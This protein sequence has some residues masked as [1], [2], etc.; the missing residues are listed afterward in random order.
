MFIIF[1][2]L[3]LI[4]NRNV[5]IHSS[6]ENDR[7]FFCNHFIYLNPV[8][9]FLQMYITI[10]RKDLLLVLLHH[11]LIIFKSLLQVPVFL[12]FLCYFLNNII[13]FF[14]LFRRGKAWKVMWTLKRSDVWRLF[15]QKTAH[16]LTDFIHFRWVSAKS[17][18]ST[19][20]MGTHSTLIFL[21]ISKQFIM[22]CWCTVFTVIM[23]LPL[24]SLIYCTVHHHVLV[25]KLSWSEVEAKSVSLYLSFNISWL[26]SIG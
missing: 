19:N 7:L 1:Y 14:W 8:L 24:L 11:Y 22:H 17:Y 15:Y 21:K 12:C 4:F 20:S 23:L 6:G 5:R 9:T 18:L 26:V 2:F 10:W 25:F 16:L 3:L 13:L